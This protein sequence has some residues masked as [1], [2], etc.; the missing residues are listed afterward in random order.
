LQLFS[1]SCLKV[2][3]YVIFQTG[4]CSAPVFLILT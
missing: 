4:L 1:C 3:V 2:G